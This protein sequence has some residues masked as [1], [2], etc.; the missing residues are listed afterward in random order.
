MCLSVKTPVLSSLFPL[1][2]PILLLERLPRESAPREGDLRGELPPS[3]ENMATT[4]V[5]DRPKRT[6]ERIF[7]S[8]KDLAERY[9]NLREDTSESNL[10]LAKFTVL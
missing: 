9:L 1:N 6:A 5:A 10:S 8:N 2:V 3:A 4:G 7:G